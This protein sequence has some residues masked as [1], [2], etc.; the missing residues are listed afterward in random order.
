MTT[1]GHD[2]TISWLGHATFH[3]VTPGGKRLLIDA[4]TDTNP[5]CPDEWKQRIHSEGVDYILVTH[6]HFDHVNDLLSLATLTSAKIVCQFDI[7]PW[8]TSKGVNEAQIIGFNKGGTIDLGGVKAT[9]THATHS[10]TLYDDGVLVPMGSEAGYLL[11]M[12]NGF[13]IYHTGDS[14]V[15][16]DMQII[17]AL[18]K[19]E[20]T[21]LPIGD[22]FT[23][24]PRQAAYALKLIGSRYAIPS[25]YATF[26]LLTGTPEA[27][28]E[29]LLEFGVEAEV[30]VLKPG[31]AVQ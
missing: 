25:H 22:H 10:S 12:E 27:L 6:G 30:I 13:V 3:I 9:M 1:L 31:E 4:W 2:T 23:M 14:A 16:S 24:G 29:H 21:I 28:R 18:Y 26:P 20:L 5:A 7:V 8:L 11:E 17:G 19:P 15:T